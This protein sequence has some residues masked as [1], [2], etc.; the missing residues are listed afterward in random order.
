MTSTL[1]PAPDI[2]RTSTRRPAAA[3]RG[4]LACAVLAAVALAGCDEE[5]AAIEAAFYDQQNAFNQSDGATAVASYT[6]RS[7]VFYDNLLEH[8]L[9]SEDDVVRRLAPAAQGE[10]VMMRNRCDVKQLEAMSGRD[11][12]QHA[13]D[14][15]WYTY[16][17]DPDRP[18]YFYT[19]GRIDVAS[20]GTTATA[21]VLID[22]VPLERSLE[23]TFEDG[24]WKCEIDSEIAQLS[25]ELRAWAVDIRTP[26]REL[27]LMWEGE[28]WGEVRPDIWKPLKKR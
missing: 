11:W 13:T 23:Y 2:P 20:D 28:D 9:T 8:A 12:V 21:Q 4:L 3:R 17:E 24:R 26:I 6:A 18:E 14:E 19:I 10:L 22:G 25:D 5:E 27:I 1:A 7:F 16:E 15:G